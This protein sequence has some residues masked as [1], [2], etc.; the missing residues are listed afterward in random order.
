MEVAA[1]R[2]R[3]RR[4]RRL[5]HRHARQVLG[6]QPDDRR[7]AR[8]PHHV[9]RAAGRRD[10]RAPSRTSRT[11]STSKGPTSSPSKASTSHDMPRAGLR[12]VNNDGVILRGNNDR[13]QHHV[14]HPHRLVARTSS[15]R[16]TS[17][18]ARRSSTASTSAT[19]PTA[20][21]SATTSSGATTTAASSSTPTATC[22]ATA[23]TRD[24]LVEGNVDL[25]QR[26]AAAARRSTSTASRTASSATTCST[27]ITPPASS[28][29]SA[30]RPIRL[31]EQP[32]RQQHRR[33]G[34]GRPLGPADDG[35]QLAATRSSTT[36]CSTRTPTAA[37]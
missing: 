18:R 25:R 3:Q 13:P 28:S 29:T 23:S 35:R 16:T 26:H 33:H 31:D 22:P 9:P 32:R 4:P 2:R 1:A 37:A 34:R 6:L 27:T 36:S 24:N 10:R 20:P 15:S 14:G 7:Q 11:A 8:R 30:S 5:R 17:P 12:S 21:S 19:R